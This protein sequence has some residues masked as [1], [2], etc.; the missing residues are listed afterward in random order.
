MRLF[1]LSLALLTFSI[2]GY[3]QVQPNIGYEYFNLTNWDVYADHSGS[4]NPSS[5]NNLSLPQSGY[6]TTNINL[7]DPANGFILSTVP[8]VGYARVTSAN[9]K[10]DAYGKFPV[11][12]PFFGSGKHSL[13]L[14]YD[15]LSSSVCQGVSYNIHVPANDNNFKLVYYYAVCIE[16]PGSGHLPWEKPFFA[17]NAFDSADV[18]VT[19]PCAQFTVDVDTVIAN[20]SFYGNWK[21]SA[22]NS[23][24]G[25]PVY[26]TAWTPSTIFIKNMA[27]H[28]ITL[29]FLSAGCSP[30]FGSSTGSP[31]SHFGYA[32]VD[33]DSTDNTTYRGDTIKLCKN[34]T[35]LNFNPAPGFKKYYIYDSATGVLLAQ[36]TNRLSNSITPISMC[37]SKMPKW[38]SKI[39]VVMVPPSG[40]GCS[41]T[42]YYF[43]DTS[44]T[45][46]LPPIT[47]VKDSLCAGTS[48]VISNTAT[49]GKWVSTNP[50]V[51]TVTGL[52]TT[53]AIFTGVTG[54]MDSVIYY[55]KN[56]WGCADTSTF[57]KFFVVGHPLPPIKGKIGVCIG[58]TAHL[59]DSITGGKWTVD[60][61]T[62]ATV[63]SNG[64]VK[65][66]KFGT[67]IIKYKYVNYFGCADSVTKSLQ[68]G[69]PPLPAIT[70]S[71]TVCVTHIITLK[72]A[73]TGGKWYSNNTA[74]GTID[75]LTGVFTGKDSGVVRVKYVY[76]LGSCADSVFYNVTVKA[77]IVTQITGSNSVCE[78]HTTQLS[79]ASVGGTWVNLNTNIANVSN[80]GLVTP[81]KPGTD[82]IKY[83]LPVSNGCFDS[84]YTV[85]T[86]NHTPV[87][88]PIKGLASACFGTPVTFTDTTAGGKWV[89]TDTTI[90]KISASGSVIYVKPGGPV[91]YKYIVTNAAGCSDSSL[92][93]FTVNTVPV[94]NAITGQGSVCTGNTTT[95]TETTAGGVWTIAD[96]TIA[97]V[98]GGTVTGVK[99]GTTT[100]KYTVTLGSCSDSA[101]YNVT[102]VDYP[103]VSAINGDSVLCLGHTDSYSSSPSTGVWSVVDPSV[104]TVDANGIVTPV[105]LGN[106]SIEYKVTL[107]PG[108]SVTKSY[109]IRVNTFSISLVSSPADTIIQTN[110]VSININASNPNYSVLAWLPTDNFINQYATSQ[111]FKTDS[112]I[113][114]RVVAKSDAG[115]CEDTASIKIVVT[116]LTTTV[117]VAN[118]LKINASNPV[119]S[120]IKVKAIPALKAMEFKI[121]NQWGELVYSTSDVNGSWDGTV[122]GTVQPV[123]VYVYVLKATTQDNKSIS[124]KGSITLVK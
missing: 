123:G 33:V 86:V 23:S 97:T 67:V 62:I 76:T 18:T 94:V 100:V 47:S 10:V 15:S 59:S 39:E 56:I 41:D 106:T 14:G 89:S 22:I 108:C 107:P 13:K 118:F 85:V 2:V 8:A 110:P 17:V 99:G 81:I 40:F 32:Y 114:I 42:L 57:K 78:K 84:V 120:K 71:N 79:N 38:K 75:S 124:K 72:D 102:V 19:L 98:A 36:D 74:L 105:K 5:V 109:N 73:T 48:L 111:T 61:S 69:M 91:P 77:P 122:N 11:V 83:I 64:V 49:G 60:N 53:S 27:G 54:G 35:C 119:N 80:S 6:N 96:N 29:Q 66:V 28:T 4:V 112:T 9:Q 115:S 37:G 26:Y 68:I 50:T 90:F 82:T 113:I 12:C 44:T 88:G 117:F 93:A 104:A 7:F 1:L 46:I 45:R 3:S 103:V 65:G 63:D 21:K 52:N 87:V 30:S 20:P 95:L 121:F 92:S 34:D 31:G 16:D 43:I 55:A 58:D 25:N 101:K 24:G 116:P 70:G 51:A